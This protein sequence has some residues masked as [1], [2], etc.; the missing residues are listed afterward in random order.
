MRCRDFCGSL[1]F[2]ADLERK[3]ADDGNYES[4]K[5]AAYCEVYGNAWEDAREDFYFI[6]DEL[7]ESLVKREL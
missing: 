4:F 2:L 5:K 6:Q 1:P 3:L 7:V